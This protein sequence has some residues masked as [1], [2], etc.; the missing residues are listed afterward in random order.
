[1]AEAATREDWSRIVWCYWSRGGRVPAEEA[2]RVGRAREKVE[3]VPRALSEQDIV[4]AALKLAAKH[5]FGGLTMR[6]LADEL[7]VTPMAIYYHVANKEAL[8]EL[9]TDVILAGIE[10]PR[11]D[12]GDW[13]TRLWLLHLESS[14]VI[15]A[16]PGLN[17]M[18]L[19]LGLTAQVR[20]LMDANIEILLEAGFDAR[21]A[22][23]AYN[24]LH[25]YTVGRGIIETRVRGKPRPSGRTPSGDYPALQRV[26]DHVGAITAVEYRAFGFDAILQ[27]LR[28]MLQS[29]HGDVDTGSRAIG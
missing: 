18:M 13:T 21:S 25:A 28:H 29:L 9:L 16:Y 22:L 15:D 11:P 24:V 10:V 12:A 27:G 5:G 19:D 6:A 23:L 2:S 4:A 7:D 17:A 3:R 20:R 26:H 8:L 14:R 1:L